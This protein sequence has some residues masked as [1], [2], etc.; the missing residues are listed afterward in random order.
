ATR[1]DRRTRQRPRRAETRQLR[2]VHCRYA[3]RR[4]PAGP[5]SRDRQPARRAAT[6][7]AGR[8]PARRDRPREG[9]DLATP[10]APSLLLR[11]RRAEDALTHQR[12]P[13]P[14]EPDVLGQGHAL[15]TG[16]NAVVEGHGRR[17]EVH[18]DEA[19]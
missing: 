13:G 4:A 2:G 17:L 7:P 10:L 18:T 9:N 15:M 19:G 14:H 11:L 6:G 1:P 3:A 5:P 12:Q 16:P 8:T